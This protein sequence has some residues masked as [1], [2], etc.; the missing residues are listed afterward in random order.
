MIRICR[1]CGDEYEPEQRKHRFGFIDQCDDCGRRERNEPD[2]SLGRRGEKGIGIEIFRTNLTN[3]RTFL[4]NENRAF[5]P[6]G[7]N[8]QSTVESKDKEDTSDKP[9]K[10]TGGW[11]DLSKKKE[12]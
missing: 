2:R 9:I 6:T 11:F 5:G 8:L 7:L 10:E 12:V 4:R 3:V 1:T